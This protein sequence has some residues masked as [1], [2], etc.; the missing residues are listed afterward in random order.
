MLRMEA[1]M[2]AARKDAKAA[3]LASE[4]M[5]KKPVEQAE[6]YRGLFIK[7]EVLFKFA[8]ESD[9]RAKRKITE[10]AEKAR[11]FLELY[12]PGLTHLTIL[13]EKEKC[14][15]REKMDP[16]HLTGFGFLPE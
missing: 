7:H 15:A 12:L 14:F 16:A 3:R 9:E 11:R 8:K 4:K 2:V 13:S 10:L 6:A 5:K 1:M